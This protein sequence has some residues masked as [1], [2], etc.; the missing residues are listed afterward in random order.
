[1]LV[2]GPGYTPA[3]G[4]SNNS[5]ICRVPGFSAASGGSMTFTDYMFT[6]V[7]R[8][9]LTNGNQVFRLMPSPI[10]LGCTVS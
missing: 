3:L 2:A 6:L 10:R 9:R 1:M 7:W 5:M 8:Q 4:S